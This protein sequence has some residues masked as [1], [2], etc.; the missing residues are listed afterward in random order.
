[1]EFILNHPA[2]FAKK[3]RSKKQ[4]KKTMK[5]LNKKDE[6]IEKNK[7]KVGEYKIDDRDKEIYELFKSRKQELIK[8]RQNVVGRNIEDIWKAADNAYIPHELKTSGGTKGFLNED[9]GAT[10]VPATFRADDD[11]QEDSAPA[12]P[13]IKIQ[14]AMSILID[15]NP[16]AVFKAATKQYESSSL[17]MKELYNNNWDTAKSKEQLKLLVL[18][19]AKYGVFC[20]R[21]AV[22]DIGRE[23]R[24][25][26]NYDP[27][28]PSKN[29]YETQ[30][31]TIYNDV[32]RWALDPWKCWFDDMAKPGEPFSMN[33][34]M[35][36]EDV[37]WDAFVEKFGKFKNFKYVTPHKQIE[38][39]DAE[40]EKKVIIQAENTI[41]L[42]FYEN[43]SRD[44]FYLQ[45]ED[46]IVLVNEPIPFSP[47]NK[48]LSCWVAPWTLR[49]QSSVYGI[50]VYEAMRNDYKLYTKIRNMTMDQ[51]VQSIYKS[52]FYEGTSSATET[53][54]I[55]TKP[56]IGIQMNNAKSIVWNEVP[57]PGKDAWAGIEF[58]EKQ[59]DDST[60]I[61]KT[62]EGELSPNA[63]AF[64]IAQTREAS[65]RRMKLPLDNLGYV[66]E[67]DAYISVALFEE[68]YSEP[69]V[70]QITDPDKIEE[71]R[72]QAAQG[73]MMPNEMMNNED[74]S[75][76]INKFREFPIYLDRD[77]EGNILQ[78]K[79]EKFFKVKPE[80]LGW[81]GKI[82]ITGQSV[83]AES[84]L[85]EKQN[86]LE[87]ANLLI[88]L[89]VQPPEVVMP[90]AKQI[91]KAYDEDPEDWLP[92]T[93]LQMMQQTQSGEQP[94]P[95]LFIDQ[96][97]AQPMGQ[98]KKVVPSNQ[99]KPTNNK[100]AAFN[101]K[102]N[103]MINPQ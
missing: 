47:K 11:W 38:S 29:T 68:L 81:E 65:L 16:K 49:H 56:G 17:L 44:T 40:P 96:S 43:L 86:K 26:T 72:K 13:Y 85:L 14:T 27:S 67:L 103:P 32:Y 69:E 21:T 48:R 93:W 54:E 37:S 2:I 76:T 66:L 62:L 80:D 30:Y 89:F 50:G 33:D 91:L 3:K 100:V 101:N 46:G 95:Q 52:W 60:G 71:Y 25:I 83:I 64:D 53:G 20:G 34:W 7:A 10:S 74:G 51:L 79:E 75:L 77:K 36:Y 41:R 87:M 97:Q 57:G 42:W 12:S 59:I 92:T 5:K 23:V 15:R 19:G 39:S 9:G 99:A 58:S 78:T 22:L 98:A 94:Q 90:A 45:T 8:S 24:D 70:L 1:M 82:C 6:Q 18:N 84:P 28:D 73:I 102:I 61:T 4:R 31:I 55:R 35:R 88:P 63:K